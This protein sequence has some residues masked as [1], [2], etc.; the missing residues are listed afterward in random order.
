M[1]HT[2]TEPLIFQDA[3]ACSSRNYSSQQRA[4][5]GQS[6]RSMV[7]ALVNQSLEQT[8]WID[9]KRITDLQVILHFEILLVQN[10]L[11]L[12]FLSIVSHYLMK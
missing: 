9:E 5:T 1:H 6:R 2:V 11:S 7:E 12:K 4:S 3:T 8:K 10:L